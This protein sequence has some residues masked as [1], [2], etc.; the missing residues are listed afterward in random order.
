MS[1]CKQVYFKDSEMLE[2][3]KQFLDNQKNF[4]NS[5]MY[6]IEKEVAKNGVRN[7]GE[8][9]PQVR[10]KEY[11]DR[12][13]KSV[14]HTFPDS[15]TSTDKPVFNTVLPDPLPSKS[16]HSIKQE[17]KETQMEIATSIETDSESE[18]VDIPS[19]YDEI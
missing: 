12:F 15:E 8:Y 5:I 7:L 19:C 1:F 14:P 13:F 18:S 10:S 6:L 4:S 11:W 17:E 16:G 2:L 9:I 3:V